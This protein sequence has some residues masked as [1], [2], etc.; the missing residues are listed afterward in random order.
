MS[1]LIN[2]FSTPYLFTETI[3]HSGPCCGKKIIAFFF[4]SLTENIFGVSAGSG[5]KR[6]VMNQS[7][8]RGSER[9]LFVV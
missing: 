4:V 8:D 6:R 5:L 1:S 9:A 2:S 7:K 3:L